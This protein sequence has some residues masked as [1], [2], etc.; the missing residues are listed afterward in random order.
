MTDQIP[1]PEKDPRRAAATSS[2][3]VLALVVLAT[4]SGPLGAPRSLC[5]AASTIGR[6]AGTLQVSFLAL[7]SRE[8]ATAGRE[9]DPS[10]G[11]ARP[12][13]VLSSAALGAPAMDASSGFVR[14]R[15]DLPPPMIG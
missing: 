14:T 10:I 9:A 2:S 1:N 15:T 11:H 3:L 12:A 7:A 13:A 5:L 6:S 4:M 8:R